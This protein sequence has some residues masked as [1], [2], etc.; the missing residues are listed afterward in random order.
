MGVPCR[1]RMLSIFSTFDNMLKVTISPQ[2]KPAET[3]P[4][5]DT[6]MRARLQPPDRR[7]QGGPKKQKLRTQNPHLHL[8]SENKHIISE[9]V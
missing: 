2:A 4:R 9:L 6:P 5:Q 8:S 1:L 7:A 3:D